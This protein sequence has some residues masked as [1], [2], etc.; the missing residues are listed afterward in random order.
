MLKTVKFWI[1]SSAKFGNV[2]AMIH[3]IVQQVIQKDFSF[4]HFFCHICA[5]V[6]LNNLFF[7]S[8]N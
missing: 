6:L 8:N 7:A 4:K 5:L 1:F 2:S 3:L